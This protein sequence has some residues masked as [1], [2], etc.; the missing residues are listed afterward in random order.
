MKFPRRTRLLRNPFD[1]TAYAAVFFLMVI[2]LSLGS[3]LYTPGVSIDL[4][5]AADQA[6]TDAPTIWVAMDESGRYYFDNQNIEPAA[7]RTRLTAIATQAP[8]PLTL[9]ILMD[10]SVRFEDL[11]QLQSLARE[12]GIT[13]T[14]VATQ[15]KAN[16][17]SA[18]P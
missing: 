1:A 3:R 6:G 18:Q 4:P 10:K 13:E 14:L 17:L 5:R 2:F 9:V 12:A 15:P 8:A 11:L 7:L 16:Q